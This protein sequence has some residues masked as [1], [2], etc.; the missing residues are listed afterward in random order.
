MTTQKQP[1][2]SFQAPFQAPALQ[3]FQDQVTHGFFTKNGGVS[4]GDFQ[5]LNVGMKKEDP[6]TAVLENRR[7]VAE[8]LGVTPEKLFFMNQMHWNEVKNLE[9]DNI[10]KGF[11][12]FKAPECDALI[13]DIPGIALGVQT[14]DCLPILIYDPKSP[15]IA[16]VHAGWRGMVTGVIQ[17]TLETMCQQ[18]SSVEDLL[19][20]LGPSIA[21]E[22]YEVGVDIFMAF[23]AADPNSGQFFMKNPSEQSYQLDLKGYAK[24]ILL[25]LG[26]TKVTAF[27]H[28]T[29]AMEDTY[30]SCRRAYHKDQ[31]SFGNQASCI[32][33]K[34]A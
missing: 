17:N 1:A 9:N 8:H 21:K 31:A 10:V 11:D 7:L 20:L 19:I 27:A 33:L 13:T 29:Y 14:A 22:S 23:Q 26:V 32:M 6:L 4:Q 16:A 3:K 2:D 15:R 30:F 5:S 25:D 34:Q 24:K 28:D 18:G 12:P